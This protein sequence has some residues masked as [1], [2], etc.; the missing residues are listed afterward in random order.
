MAILFPMQGV[1][2]RFTQIQPRLIFSVNA[3]VYNGK[4]HDHM[5]K[6]EKVVKGQ[7]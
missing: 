4:V 5:E 7:L 6:L 2:E 1:L 3:V